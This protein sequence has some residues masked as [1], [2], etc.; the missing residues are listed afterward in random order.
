MFSVINAL[1][2]ASA[3]GAAFDILKLN[4]FKKRGG[5]IKEINKLKPVD[6]F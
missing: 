6:L 2:P 5:S 4:F 1:F 3:S